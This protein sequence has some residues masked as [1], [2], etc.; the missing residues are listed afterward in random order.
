MV[1]ILKGRAA[2]QT[3]DRIHIM[4]F[5]NSLI[6]LIQISDHLGSS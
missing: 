4:A 6:S 3:A 2:H 5:R 1:K